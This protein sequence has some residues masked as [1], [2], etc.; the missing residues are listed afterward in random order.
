MTF[1]SAGYPPYLKGIFKMTL[2]YG[3]TLTLIQLVLKSPRQMARNDLHEELLRL[4]RTPPEFYAGVLEH[5]PRMKLTAEQW[6][7]FFSKV[8]NKLFLGDPLLMEKLSPSQ[9]ERLGLT[10]P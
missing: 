4:R 8:P 5:G 3:K 7:D 9:R 1:S 10:D 2:D 6:F